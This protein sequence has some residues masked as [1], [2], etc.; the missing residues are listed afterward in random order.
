MLEVKELT[1]YYGTKCAVDHISFDLEKGHIL[2]MLGING[3]GKSTMM[4][5]ITGYLAPTEGEVIID[6][7]SMDSQPVKA[8]KQIG[9]LPE[10]PPLYPDMTV[11]EY[12]NFM[13]RL[14]KIRLLGRAHIE[15]ICELVGI[16]EV[17]NRLIR[18]LSKGYGQR[19]GIAQALLGNPPLV[20]LDEPTVGLDP[21]QIIEIRNLIRQI[22]KEQTII[23]SSHILSEVQSVCDRIIII[24]QGKVV[25]D[26]TAANLETNNGKRKISLVVAAPPAE[27]ECLL[28]KIPH[29]KQVIPQER[30]T[31]GMKE[32][33]EKWARF[34]L[35]ADENYDSH[36]EL[37][38]CIQQKGWDID[39][40]CWRKPDLEE[41]F[42]SLVTG[43]E[44][45]GRY[46]K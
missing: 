32:K 17:K 25:A 34:L 37:L 43:K 18:N 39:S 14:K 40:L 42:L 12:L 22:G 10:K 11:Q 27:A 3:A 16:A 28:K 19:V 41:I 36:G 21:Q 9:Y 7:I 15:E 8:R 6:G 44:A 2:G 45:E 35:V 29:I 30:D 38:R 20:I 23:L 1:R 26:D 13:F 24:H 4:N 31:T 46:E 5:M 33:S